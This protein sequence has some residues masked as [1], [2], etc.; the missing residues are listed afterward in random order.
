MSAVAATAIVL[1]ACSDDDEKLPPIDGYNNSNEVAASNLVAHWTFDDNNNEVISNT[2]PANTYGS[3][4]STTGQIGKGIQLSQG[5]L[6]YPSITAIG[7]ENSLNDFTVS[8]W[9]NV[10]NNGNSFTT[11]FGIFPTAVAEPW[12]NLSAS[13]E[14][15]WFPARDAGDTLVLKANY[16]SNDNGTLNGQDNRPDPRGNPPVG[17]FKASGQ[18]INFV[19]RFNSSTHKLQVFGNGTSIGAYDFRGDNTGA[20]HMRTPAQAVIGSLAANDIGFA[21]AGARGDW[22]KMATALLDDIRVYNTALSDA[23]IT[24]LYNLGTAGR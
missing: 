8:L 12:G 14:T 7:G 5:S 22:M 23:E 9:T 17:L 13:V 16:L 18:W 10:N 20:L 1:G 2:A 3:V 11:L 15:G 21:S 6:V 19:I 24:A 4:T